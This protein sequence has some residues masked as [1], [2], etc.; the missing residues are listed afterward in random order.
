MALQGT[1][2][3]APRYV[4]EI[5]AFG[6]VVVLVLYLLATNHDLETA[7]PILALYAF[8]GYRLMPAFQ[9]IFQSLTVARFNW[10]S[11]ELVVGEMQRLK[12]EDLR[13]LGTRSRQG[14]FPF[15]DRIGL[16]SCL[17]HLSFGCRCGSQGIWP[18]GQKEHHHWPRWGD[19]L[20]KDDYRRSHPR[21]AF[22]NQRALACRWCAG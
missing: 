8:T 17:V 9:A 12:R 6:S 3:A 14:R 19:R 22:T 4:M 5:I 1:I 2:G 13:Q 10:P 18:A 7:L 15:H 11:V 20:R 16:R 21:H